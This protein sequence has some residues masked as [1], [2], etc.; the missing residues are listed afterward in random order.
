MVILSILME[1]FSAQSQGQE[2]TLLLWFYCVQCVLNEPKQGNTWLSSQTAAIGE[3]VQ[4]PEIYFTYTY[5]HPH[6]LHIFTSLFTYIIP[7]RSVLYSQCHQYHEYR[8][9]QCSQK[10]IWGHKIC[11]HD[12]LEGEQSWL[13]ILRMWDMQRIHPTICCTC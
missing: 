7:F 3:K 11:F 13:V 10:N 12:F 2:Q 8:P 9:C 1:S 4:N 6:F 5:T